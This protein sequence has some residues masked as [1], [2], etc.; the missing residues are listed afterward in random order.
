MSRHINLLNPAL[1][2]Q[3]DN[4]NAQLLVWL[5]AGVLLL[6]LAIFGY[7]R[8][9]VAL[10]TAQREQVGQQMKDAQSQLAQAT[11][12]YAPRQPSKAL[13]EAVVL[14]EARLGSHQYLLGYLQEDKLGSHSGFSNY[15]RAFARKSIGDLWLTGF[16]ID[17]DAN[18]MTIHGRALQ[19]ELVPQYI[20]QLGD[21][22]A[23]KGHTFSALNMSLPK[24][25]PVSRP[26]AGSPAT[27]VVA[28]PMPLIEFEL[29]SS[30]QQDDGGKKS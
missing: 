23:L 1:I 11:Q 2:R 26:A 16:S 24:D 12:Q 29:K 15:M 30:G 4:F 22:P 8:Y 21:E 14:A 18:E 17:H 6:L 20:G 28:H 10:L 13:Q 5:S 25:E 19:P 7:M 3:R 9:Q 27:P